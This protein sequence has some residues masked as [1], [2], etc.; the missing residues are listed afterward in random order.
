MKKKPR[1]PFSF[2]L[3]NLHPKE[4][5]V[6]PMFGCFAV[7]VD[8]KLVLVLRK[9]ESARA[10]NGVWI[11]TSREHHASLLKEFPSMRSLR[12]L[13]SVPTNWQNIPESS[14]DFESEVLRACELIVKGDPRIGKIPKL[15]TRKKLNTR[16]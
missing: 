6:K 11:G 15:K 1:I 8:R 16:Q 3:E 9:K 5:V 7:Y 14:D 10:D 12:L 13:G 2:V 4:P